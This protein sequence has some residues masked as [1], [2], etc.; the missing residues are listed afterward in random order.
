MRGSAPDGL[1]RPGLV[2][3]SLTPFGLVWKIAPPLSAGDEP[4]VLDLHTETTDGWITGKPEGGQKAGSGQSGT[5]G[6]SW[7]R[8][9]PSSA[10]YSV[11]SSPP[12]RAADPAI[13]ALTDA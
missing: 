6:R 7:G 13:R 1:S 12:L 5:N 8:I 10:C 2:R 11:A 9:A 4:D 3:S